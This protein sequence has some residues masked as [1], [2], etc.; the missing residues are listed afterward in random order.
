M[1]VARCLLE[2]AR[3]CD[4][5]SNCRSPISQLVLAPRPH[6]RC[7]G[8]HRRL[9][10]AGGLPWAIA[11]LRKSRA[12]AAGQRGVGG[13][14][15]PGCT[16]RKL[17][18]TSVT[19][20]A[21]NGNPRTASFARRGK[22]R[23][24]RPLLAGARPPVGHAAAAD[25]RSA[26]SP[27]H[28]PARAHPEGPQRNARVAR[29]PSPRR[30]WDAATGA[31]AQLRYGLQCLCEPGQAARG[32]ALAMTPTGRPGMALVAS[33]AVSNR[34]VAHAASRGLQ[35]NAMK[36]RAASPGGNEGHPNDSTVA[37]AK[38]ARV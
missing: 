32:P 9:R 21:A 10:C 11:E 12:A 29:H 18:F 22:P 31:C 19:Q 33:A 34:Q 38:G 16:R 6:L 24:L 1:A 28:P 8:G 7:S 36:A 35:L 20:L 15:L 4:R 23:R 25:L 5:H 30:Q 37:G 14:R 27:Q 13:S 17:D 2:E 26:S 3:S